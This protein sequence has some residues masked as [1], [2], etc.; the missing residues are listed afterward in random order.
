MT[1][2]AKNE[3][4]EFSRNLAQLY[5]GCPRDCNSDLTIDFEAILLLQTGQL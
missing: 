3:N 4:F 1:I 2:Q 5:V